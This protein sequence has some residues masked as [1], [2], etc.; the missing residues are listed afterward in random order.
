MDLLTPMQAAGSSIALL[1]LAYSTQDGV[2]WNGTYMRNG[3]V[4]AT[5]LE[6][7]FPP[8]RRQELDCSNLVP[9]QATANLSGE[10]GIVSNCGAYTT[11]SEVQNS[12]EDDDYYCRRTPGSQEFAFRFYEYN[13]DDQQRTY[14]FFKNRIVTASAGECIIYPNVTESPGTDLDLDGDRAAKKFTFTNGSFT[15]S[16]SIPKA[17]DGLSGTTYIYRGIKT[18]GEADSPSVVCGPRCLWMWVHK[19]QGP[20]DKSTF[21]QCPITMSEVSNASHDYQKIKDIM[22]RTAAASIALHGGWTG[23]FKNQIF[24]SFNFF[25]AGYVG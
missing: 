8:H 10:M 24:T 2:D 9:R 16:I 23:T 1:N 15:D 7:Y 18:P 12:R 3:T 21:Y 14:P 13:P 5:N 4:N 22:A 19:A 17:N 6:C 20:V 25:A 11:I